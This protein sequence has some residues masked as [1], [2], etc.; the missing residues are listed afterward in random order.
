MAQVSAGG[1]S[2][3]K[4][5]AGMYGGLFELRECGTSIGTIYALKCT[6]DGQEIC[7]DSDM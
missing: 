3:P 1:V 7:D 5:L 2:M 4:L 6:A